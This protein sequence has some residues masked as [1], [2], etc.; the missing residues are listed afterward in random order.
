MVKD[1]KLYDILEINVD[2]TEQEI[3]KAYFKLSKKWHPDRNPPE[4]KEKCTAKFQEIS[5]ANT[6]LSDPEKRKTYDTTG[7]TEDN[8]QGSNFDPADL[9]SAFGGMGGM[10]GMGNMFGGM[11]GGRR[12][13]EDCVVEQNV[14]LEDIFTSKKI[15]VKYKQQ[16]YCGTCNGNGSK[17]GKPNDCKGCHGKGQK[18]RIIKQGNM[19]QQFMSPCEDCGGSGEKVVKDNICP[20]C[21]GNKKQI[22]EKIFE[23]QLNKKYTNNDKIVVEQMG[24][25]LKTG[26][27][28]LIIIIK[29]QP[30]P[31]FTRRGNNLHIDMKLRLF[32]SIYG[33]NKVVT[34]LDG[35]NIVL[36]YEKTISHMNTTMIVKGAGMDSKGDLYVNIYTHMPKLD[37]LDEQ[38]NN[39]LKKLMVKMHL[40]EYVKDQNI[41]KNEDK[42]E[43][44]NMTEIETPNTNKHENEHANGHANEYDENMKGH[45]M[46][47]QCAQQ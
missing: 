13:Q 43:I 46:P 21:F 41:G 45:E 30:H 36:K 9:F 44:F 39:I 47:V 33:F 26:K 5:D 29:E 16:V 37:R 32:Q 38:E 28:N 3:K 15:P 20:D 14:K 24:H 42:L 18:I 40:S 2:A 12:R 7:M 25:Q 17:D 11:G 35:K 34:H 23:L 31:I 4:D 27:T 22:K 8:M 10:G 19:I 6:I 1:K